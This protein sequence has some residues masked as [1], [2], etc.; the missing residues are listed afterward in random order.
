[1]T[2]WLKRISRRAVLKAGLGGAAALAF[3]D[4]AA[5][6]ETGQLPF[7]ILGDWGWD[8]ALQQRDV[9]VQMGREASSSGSRFVISVGDNFYEDGVESVDDPH[10]RKSF[11]EIYDAP[12][13]QAPW[14]VALGNHDYRGNVDA[15]IAY[16]SK[17]TR[18]RMPARYF[19]RGETVPGA[20][21]ADFFFLDTSPFVEK[22]RGSNTRI[23][24]QDSR[25]QLAWFEGALAKSTAPWKIVTGHH[26]VFS[27]GRDHGNTP[28]LIR[29]VKPLLEKYG[30]RAYFFGHDHDLQH[31]EVAGVHYIGCGG[32]GGDAPD[33]DDRG[34]QVRQRPYRFLQR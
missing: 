2:N 13:L 23:D 18:W 29:D 6:A 26:P 12:S 7:L 25:A 32:G 11:E 33:I 30:V 27:G 28:E 24:G 10:F 31:I 21:A 16:S 34:Q 22:Y 14:Y 8:G 15:E 5:Q 1:M 17:S 3:L 9:A 19:S 4:Q 20:G